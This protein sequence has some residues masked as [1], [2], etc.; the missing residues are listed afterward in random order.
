MIK[1]IFRSV[2]HNEDEILLFAVAS[3]LS[4]QDPFHG[5]APRDFVWHR[6]AVLQGSRIRGTDCSKIEGVVIQEQ[7]AHVKTESYRLIEP[8]LWFDAQGIADRIAGTGPYFHRGNEQG[9]R[10][11]T[12]HGAGCCNRRC[13]D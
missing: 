7:G 4:G 12:G 3:S 8:A 1:K 13:G 5:D 6:E 11:G 9:K 10:G 2:S